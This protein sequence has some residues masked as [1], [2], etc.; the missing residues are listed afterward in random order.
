VYTINPGFSTILSKEYSW[1]SVAGEE[2]S[3]ESESFVSNNNDPSYLVE[4]ASAALESLHMLKREREEN[5]SLE[6]DMWCHCGAAI[7]RG[8][9][10]EEA[11]EREWSMDEVIGKFQ[12]SAEKS[13]GELHLLKEWILSKIFSKCGK[14]RKT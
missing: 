11:S 14:Q 3:R 9:S 5:G 12:P 6:A 1:R 8:A 13:I 4:L 7:I 10:E 2:R